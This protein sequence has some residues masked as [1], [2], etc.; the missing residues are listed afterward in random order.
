MLLGRVSFDDVMAITEVPH[1]QDKLWGATLTNVIVKCY[2][3]EQ[4]VSLRP[5]LPAFMW[6]VRELFNGA[7]ACLKRPLDDDIIRRCKPSSQN[8]NDDTE[9]D[10]QEFEWIEFLHNMS[11]RPS[12]F[13]GQ[14]QL[15]C[16]GRNA[17]LCLRSGISIFQ[18]NFGTAVDRLQ[19]ELLRSEFPFG[20]LDH[21]R[22]G[23]GWACQKK[24]RSECLRKRFIDANIQCTCSVCQDGT[25]SAFLT[26]EMLIEL[27]I[28][29]TNGDMV[30]MEVEASA[31]IIPFMARSRDAFR[32]GMALP[33]SQQRQLAKS[34]A[35]GGLVEEE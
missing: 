26:A 14:A 2:Q 23:T 19:T 12:S 15:L 17:Q 13:R 27:G 5:M 18:A 28:S 33:A 22:V 4:G 7:G 29:L 10:G 21:L 25:E 11:S 8:S 34:F 32:D 9:N 35:G 1:F 16:N 30:R 31:Q 3:D 20:A 6:F 24:M